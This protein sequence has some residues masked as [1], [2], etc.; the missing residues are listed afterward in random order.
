VSDDEERQLRIELMTVQIDQGRLNIEKMRDDMRMEQ[1]KLTRQSIA[2][3]LS[4][5]SVV[6]AAFAAGA[7]YWH[8]FH[9]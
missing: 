4:A 7:A 5:A 2:L 1:R 9:S 3:G 6:I 8:F